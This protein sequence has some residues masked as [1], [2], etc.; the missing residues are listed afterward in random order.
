MYCIPATY[1]GGSLFMPFRPFIA[2]RSLLVL[3]CLV[4]AKPFM[5]IL[6]C[7]GAHM[8]LLVL[9]LLLQTGLLTCPRPSLAQSIEPERSSGWFPREPYMFLETRGGLSHATG[10][11]LEISRSVFE[12]AGYRATFTPLSWREMLQ[13]LE[14]GSLDF[15]SGAY[16]TDERLSYVHYSIP[17]RTERNAVYYHRQVAVFDTVRTMDQLLHVLRTVPLRLGYIEGYAYGSRQ[18]EQLITH[19]PETL[20][21]VPSTG[22]T[23]HV[24]GVL[25]READLFLSNPV[26]MR[27]LLAD[28]G[29]SAD[30]RQARVDMPDIDV[31]FMFSRKHFSEGDVARFNRI[32]EE[33]LASGSTQSIYVNTMIP[34][35]LSM[36]TGQLWFTILN[37]LGIFAFCASGVILARRERYNLFGALV[38]ATLPAIGGGVLRDILLGADQ[39]FVLR[40]PAF[41]LVAIVVVVVGFA[42][43]RI[44]DY[45]HER[46]QLAGSVLPGEAE[47][48]LGSW[49]EALF[50]FF[51]AWAVAA[52]TIIGV[53]VAIELRADPLWLWGPSMGVLTASGG[54]VLRDVVR[55]DFNMEMLKHDSYAEVSLIGGILFTAVLLLFPYELSSESIFTVTLVFIALLFGIRTY[56]LWSGMDNPFQFGATYSKPEKRMARVAAAETQLW[57][58]LLD[59]FSVS[60]QGV[61]PAEDLEEKHNRF[62]SVLAHLSGELDELA[63]EPLT[64]AIKR[65]Y[66]SFASRVEMAAA[67]EQ[68]L[69]SFLDAQLIYDDYGGSAGSE[70]RQAINELVY[71]SLDQAGR[72]VGDGTEQELIQSGQLSARQQALM[73]LRSSLQAQTTFKRPAERHALITATHKADRIIFLAGNYLQIH[74]ARR[75][76]AQ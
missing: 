51:D 75:T 21:L 17:Y 7:R 62:L 66:R 74:P 73:G 32:I 33:M 69:Y 2:F 36:A 9:S 10:L 76:S 20:T 65:R 26:I 68:T 11:D 67:M 4:F 54:V 59:F 64:H 8:P 29:V 47:Q 72:S 61:G 13:G 56:V 39:V 27:K 3:I 52:F 60:A 6:R 22:Y 19:P 15:V 42:V 70:A 46:R 49:I 57:Q 50:R 24:T 37:L 40:T 45:L 30:V 23:D 34:Y 38:L 28:A 18:I 31:H 48:Q 35:F 53:S 55:S 14:N 1:P 5:T 58:A 43:F 71:E 12:Q 25:D 16:L 44:Y 41:F 63:A